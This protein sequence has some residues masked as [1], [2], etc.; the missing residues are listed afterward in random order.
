MAEFASLDSY[1]KFAKSVKAKAECVGVEFV[2][3]DYDEET[4]EFLRMVLETSRV[5]CRTIPK[6][7]VLFRA[8]NQGT[9]ATAPLR[10]GEEEE[11]IEAVDVVAAHPLK[12]MVP[13]VE[14]V[15]KGGRLHRKGIPCLYLAT[16]AN[17]A[18]SE[19]RPWVGSYITLAKFKMLRDCRVVDCS[20]NTTISWFLEVVRDGVGDPREPDALTKEDGVWGDIGFACSKPVTH[21]EPPPD[22][23]PTQILA[24]EF[25]KHGY[26]GIVYQS[27]LDDDGLN[28]ALFD[29]N[30][31]K[32]T[33]PCLYRTKS[34]TLEVARWDDNLAWPAS[35]PSKKFQRGKAFTVLAPSREN[36]S[37]VETAEEDEP[38]PLAPGS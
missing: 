6:G 20:L 31:A 25:R 3:G 16:T 27:L 19:I 8:Q 5:R 28:I 24:D 35:I 14:K 32:G 13:K 1:W 11:A 9:W 23:I 4:R 22:Y 26:D 29:V 7:R 37:D 10:I 21:D 15:K 18:V 33:D 36:D 2:P 12:R 38:D 17:A 34:A 30:A